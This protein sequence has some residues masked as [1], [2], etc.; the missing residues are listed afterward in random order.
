MVSSPAVD[1]GTNAGCPLTDHPSTSLRTATGATPPVTR[2][3]MTFG[4]ASPA[5]PPVLPAAGP[6]ITRTYY[7][8]GAQTIAMRV[9]TGTVGNALR[10]AYLHADHLGSTSITTCGN[11][12]CGALGAELSRETY[13]P[14]G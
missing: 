9:I 5:L 4:N 1:T 10:I 12:A 2:A 3:R 11:S 14:Y 13:Y 8:A 7:Y 6:T